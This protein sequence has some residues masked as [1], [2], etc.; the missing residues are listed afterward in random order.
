MTITTEVPAGSPQIRGLQAQSLV[1]EDPVYSLARD[2][3]AAIVVDGDMDSLAYPSARHIDYAIHL[4]GPHVVSGVS[5]DWGYFGSDARYLTNWTLLGS[6]GGQNWQVLASG[7]FPGK[8]T[9]D[10]AVQSTATDLRLMADGLNSIG[11]YEVRV[12]GTVIPNL[13]SVKPVSGF[14]YSGEPDLFPGSWLSGRETYRWKPADP[15]LSSQRQ[16]GLP[17]II[18]W[19]DSTVVSFDYLG[20]FR[21]KSHIR[22]QLVGARQKRREPALDDR[23]AGRLS[24]R[25]QLV[26]GSRDGRYGPQIGGAF[27]SKQYWQL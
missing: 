21:N 16:L 18:G 15:R 5:I 12:F 22:R 1:P 6:N 2:Y 3:G 14:E 4:N 23:G 9:L 20:I 26:N 27:G 11:A 7:G 10:V 8:S 17:D 24:Q 19:R 25:S 13:A